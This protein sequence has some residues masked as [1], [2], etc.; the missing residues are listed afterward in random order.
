MIAL[1]NECLFKIFN[2]NRDSYKNLFSCLLVNRQWCRIIVPILWS[3]PLDDFRDARIINIYLLALNVEEQVQSI[4]F[5]IM[6][7]TDPKPLFDYTS[8]TTSI[9]DYHLCKGIT[10]WLNYERSKYEDVYLLDGKRNEL[11][12]EDDR[13]ITFY[14]ESHFSGPE[15]YKGYED[16]YKTYEHYENI[17]RA[18]KSSLIS[19][20]LRKSENL[21]FVGFYGFY[22]IVRNKI[23]EKL[24][25]KMLI[26]A[27]HKNVT[28]YSLDIGDNQLC[29]N[30]EKPNRHWLSITYSKNKQCN[31]TELNLL[32][33]TGSLPTSIETVIPKCKKIEITC[34]SHDQG[35]SSYPEHYGACYLST[36]GEVSIITTTHNYDDKFIVHNAVEKEPKIRYK[37]YSN[38]H[39]DYSWQIHN[40]VFLSDHPLVQSIQPGDFVGLWIRSR[41]PGWCNYIKR[42]EI[43][44]YYTV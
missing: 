14:P 19:M 24:K 41:H 22:G 43:K 35:W 6:L 15:D 42:A 5:K 10:C 1:P 2:N 27:L 33:L 4:P 32:Y 16:W 28:P 7:P 18:T 30:E 9:D 39:A 20:L 13:N 31:G 12:R 38:R 26:E 21:N 29:I 34:E 44:L 37:I 11:K 40:Y 3:K 8:Y 25:E 23:L 36:W 17:I